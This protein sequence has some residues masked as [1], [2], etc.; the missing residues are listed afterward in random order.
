[1]GVGGGGVVSCCGRRRTTIREREAGGEM[2]SRGTGVRRRTSLLEG[3]F[4]E[5]RI[6]SEGGSRKMD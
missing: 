3:G 1:M 4:F 5:R 6:I 2:D